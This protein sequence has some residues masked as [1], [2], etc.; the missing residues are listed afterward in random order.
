MLFRFLNENKMLLLGLSTVLVGMLLTLTAR[1]VISLSLGAAVAGFGTSWIF[2][3]NVARFSRVFGPAAT[4]RATPLFIC[5]TLGAAS[6][7][8]LIG[9]ISNQTGNLRIGMYVL[10]IGVGLLIV[11]Q[12]SMSLRKQIRSV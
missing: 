7:T 6:S 8:W 11:I 3:T 5:G 10:I 2:P 12:I 9:F 4:R 1:T